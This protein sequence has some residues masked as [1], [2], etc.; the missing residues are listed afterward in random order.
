MNELFAVALDLQT[1]CQAR[2]WQFCFI[3][4]LALQ[5]GVCRGSPRMWT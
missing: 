4:G 3:G 1:F 5:G 2:G